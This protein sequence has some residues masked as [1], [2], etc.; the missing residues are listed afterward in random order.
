[1]EELEILHSFAAYFRMLTLEMLVFVQSPRDDERFSCCRA[2]WVSLGDQGSSHHITSFLEK[3]KSNR[4]TAL[5]NY[6]IS[7]LEKSVEK[8][9]GVSAHPHVPK[10]LAKKPQAAA[11]PVGKFHGLPQQIT[12]KPTHKQET[13]TDAVSTYS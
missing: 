3:M 2:E 12:F 9:K 5:T 6:K 11:L 10:R 4:R 7:S 13:S 8:V 1:M